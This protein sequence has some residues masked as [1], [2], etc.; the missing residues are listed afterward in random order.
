MAEPWGVTTPTSSH[1]ILLSKQDRGAAASL[2][3]RLVTGPLPLRLASVLQ[4]AS[5]LLFLHFASVA[6]LL[7][8]LVRYQCSEY[9]SPTAATP[10]AVRHRRDRSINIYK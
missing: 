10:P 7:R 4:H 9:C 1:N 3:L 8:N 5:W 2:R 6:A